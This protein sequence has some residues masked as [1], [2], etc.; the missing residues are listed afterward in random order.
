MCSL[1]QQ[2][3]VRYGVR[4][5]I[6]FKDGENGMPCV[7]I[8]HP[9]GHGIEVYLHGACITK[10]ADCTM[11]PKGRDLLYQR[12]DA[13]FDPGAVLKY[14]PRDLKALKAQIVKGKCSWQ[15]QAPA[16]CSSLAGDVL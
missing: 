3:E 13:I 15:Q 2:L 10:W 14:V 8:T 5:Y 16:Q 7:W 1:A 9:A 6:R 4:D 12:P 11:G